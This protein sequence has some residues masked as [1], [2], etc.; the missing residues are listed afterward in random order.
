MNLVFCKIVEIIYEKVE[1]HVNIKNSSSRGIETK[2]LLTLK[3]H[4]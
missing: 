1:N 4:Q 2:M 3:Y